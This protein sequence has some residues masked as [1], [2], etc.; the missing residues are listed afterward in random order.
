MKIS[1]AFP[2]WDNCF[3]VACGIFF[4]SWP[5][6]FRLD[7]D[8]EVQLLAGKWNDRPAG[9]SGQFEGK[10]LMVLSVAFVVGVEDFG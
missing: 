7:P 10:L 3:F 9:S 4:Y 1:C 2:T 6:I 8:S 5:A